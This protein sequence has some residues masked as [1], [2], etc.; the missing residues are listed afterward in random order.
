MTEQQIE[1]AVVGMTCA[2][3]AAAVERTLSRKVPGVVSAS[4][5]FATETATVAFDPLATDPRAMA[6]AVHDAGYELILPREGA[7]EQD[8]EQ[9]ARERELKAQ[10]RDF[11]VGLAFTLPLFAVSMGRDFSLLGEWAHALWVNWL[12]LALA[13]PV[14]FYTG[15]GF[16]T[17]GLRSIRAGAANMDVLVA[18]GSS[19]AYFYSVA[20][21]MLPGVGEHVYFETAALIVT[22]IRLGKLLEARAKGQAS[23]A[24]RKLMDLAPHVALIEDED[25]QMSEAPADRV[26]RGQV[27]VVRP[28]ERVPVDGVVVSGRSAVDESMLTG[29]SIPVDKAEGEKVF[30]ATLNQQGLLKV[31]ATSVGSQ[32]ALAQIILLVRQ[33]Q[34]SKAPIQRLADKVSAVF[35]PAIIV[36]ALITLGAWWLVE[37]EFRA[38]M[39]RMVAVLVIACPCALG[40][41]TPTAIMVGTGMG[42][43]VGI[44]FKNSEALETAHRLSTVLFDK[45]GTITR[46]KPALTDW[47]PLEADGEQTLA[48]VASAEAGSEHPIARAVVEGARR[49]GLPLLDIEEFHAASGF[50]LEAQVSGRRIRVGKPTWIEGTGFSSQRVSDLAE[51]MALQGKTVMLAEVD[52]RPAGLLAVADKEKEGAR[53]AVDELRRMG[54]TPMMVT[55]DNERAA[56]AIA[57]KVG[58][59]RVVAGILPDRKEEI[60]RQIQNEGE[61]VAMVGDGINDAPSLSRADVGVAI[62]TGTDVAMEASDITLVGGELSGVARAIK[63]SRLTMRTIRQNLFWAFF[64]NVAL[65]PLAAGV[66]HKCLWVP[67]FVRDLHPAM[68]AGAMALSSLTVVMNSL[69]LARKQI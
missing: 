35:V 47:I 7:G 62:G 37:G 20:V 32:S 6:K 8:T 41:A 21:L 38:G 23:A 22:L 64:Y 15:R 42:A 69:R 49:Q 50:G 29:E 9:E 3:C 60:V 19:A 63:L 65:V 48:L 58:I 11:L 57:H 59:D 27:V 13:S 16:Y 44:L 45:T 14:Q 33:A 31:K 12:F 61:I 28:G 4:V 67:G 55:G 25:G 5:N 56:R 18:L 34:G 26:R 17:G 51:N 43:G 30:G 1:L 24:M 39:I 66:L 53:E 46:G 36:V 2:N 54:I 52:G 10:K 68:A 40:L